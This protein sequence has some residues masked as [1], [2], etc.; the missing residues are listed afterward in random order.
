MCARM[1]AGRGVATA[2]MAA[3][4]AKSE[5]DRAGAGFGAFLANIASG[6]DLRNSAG[7]LAF[8]HDYR[9]SANFVHEASAAR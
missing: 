4:S 2:D 3:G 9:R 5:C 8:R 7:V 1:T 6:G